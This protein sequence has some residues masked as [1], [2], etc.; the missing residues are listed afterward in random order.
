MINFNDHTTDPKS[1]EIQCVFKN[2]KREGGRK[3]NYQSNE[4]YRKLVP[5]ENLFMGI[6]SGEIFILEVPLITS[7]YYYF[8]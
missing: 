8:M 1:L 7:I 6:P 3:E 4:Y 2:K 5:T